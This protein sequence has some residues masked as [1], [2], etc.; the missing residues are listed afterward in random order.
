MTG[1]TN[2]IKRYSVAA[3][4]ILALLLGAVCTYLVVLRVVP[5]GFIFI[6]ASSASLSGIIITAIADGKTGLKKLLGRLLIW[7][8]RIGY[9]VFAVLFLVPAT[10]LGLWSSPL[11]GGE[12]MDLSNMLPLFQI[13]PMFIMTIITAGL[14]EELGWT[15]FLTPRLQSRYSA[16]VSSIIRGVLWGLWH[17]PLFIFSGLDHPLLESFPYSGWVS[18]YGFVA[19]MGAFILLNQIT[20]S[21]FYTW[22]FNNTKG[23]LLLVAILHG[24][25]VWVGYGQLSTGVNPNNFDNY[26]GYGVVMVVTAVVIVLTNGAK[27]LSRRHERIMHQEP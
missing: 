22:I 1:F 23:S 18:Q 9:W 20:W 6:A 15:G 25:E 2:T 12:R 4:Y 5:S 16:L 14:G 19:A 11:F 27:N 17:F 8:A 24:S 21:I 7:R 13:L 10:L 3:F 26:W